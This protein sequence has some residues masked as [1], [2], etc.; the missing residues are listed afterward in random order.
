M[1][2]MRRPFACVAILA[3]F[4]VSAFAQDLSGTFQEGVDLL[5]RGQDAE[6]LQKFKECLAMDP[7]QEEAYQLFQSTEHQIWLDLLVQGGDYELVA[8]RLMQ[9]AEVGRK[10]RSNDP[11]AIK[12]LIERINGED[13]VDR[14]KATYTLAAEHGEYAVP[15][16]LY[17]LGDQDE[18]DRRVI[19]MQALTKMGG[20]VVPPLVAALASDDAFMRRNVALTL[21]YIGD[22][23]A[24]GFL[25]AL[26]ASD[27]DEGVREAAAS[28]AAKCGGSGNALADLLKVGKAW[29]ASDPSVLMAHQVSDV[30]WRWDGKELVPV[31]VPSF[32]YNEELSKTAFYTAL[33][34]QPASNE[35]LAGVA[36]A[37]AAERGILAARAGGGEDVAA[38]QER[39]AA[40]DLAI[41]VAGTQALDLALL[42]ALEAGDESAASGLC[43][44]LGAAASAPT[45]G[46]QTAL[47][48]RT[49]GLVRGEAAVALASIAHSTGRAGGP[50]V[51]QALAEAASREVL[52]LV[53]VIDG[54][55]ARRAA[56]EQ[57]LR[58]A[59]V[60]V[61]SWPTGAR[62]LVALR[63]VA[64]VDALLVAESLPD[65]TFA[66]VADEVRAEPARASTPILVIAADAAAAQEL[67]GERVQGAVTGPEDMPKIEAALEGSMNQDREA[68]TQLAARAAQA[69]SDLAQA[70]HTELGDA[71]AKLEATLNGKPDEIAVPALSALGAAGSVGQVPAIVA[72]VA[73]SAR[74]EAVREAAGHALAGI[75][76]RSPQAADDAA[77]QT[78]NSVATAGD[79][80]FSVRRAA[81]TALGRLDLPPGI[82][83]TLVEGV[84]ANLGAEAAAGT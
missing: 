40:D 70:G 5:K 79:A 35:A 32:L 7:G 25:G 46:L 33:R 53:G 29:H 51:V 47:K 75:F 74:S 20:D 84:R 3:A 43:H 24:A 64:G 30:V 11:E 66:Q 9:L 19:H 28:A 23:R 52:R 81:A 48:S 4:S 16:L 27:P 77:I 82:R 63:Q 76:A 39:L 15:Q 8:R 45:Q 38:W 71:A 59:G 37:S 34:L 60:S 62:G 13:V 42:F 14:M 61:N 2:S 73:D 22:P 55:D 80:P 65:L 12:A 17:A 36:R 56:L 78:L 69:L 68:A 1:M 10:A 83:A 18:D 67:W 6:A 49:S 41:Q 21:G 57:S 72:V 50:D 26:A 31:E 44:A 58:D 54:D